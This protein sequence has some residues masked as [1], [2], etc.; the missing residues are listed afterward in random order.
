MSDRGS[1]VPQDA[2][3][4]RKA[5]ISGKLRKEAGQVLKAMREDRGLTQ[6]ELA[7]KVGFDYYTFIA[8]I[9]AGRGR[10]PP[11]RYGAYA[12]ALDMPS[13]EFVQTMLKYYDPV[14]YSHLFASGS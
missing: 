11:E 7:A 5:A 8:Q 14:T 13:R 9:E 12:R 2:L 6:R 10:I 4:G 3:Q 1:V